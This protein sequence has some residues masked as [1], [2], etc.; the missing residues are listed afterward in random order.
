MNHYLNIMKFSQSNLERMLNVF[1][2]DE[3]KAKAESNHENNNKKQERSPDV[4]SE[5]DLTQKI[6][7]YSP[8]NLNRDLLIQLGYGRVIE[9]YAV[10][11]LIGGS[12]RAKNAGQLGDGVYGHTYVGMSR[13]GYLETLDYLAREIVLFHEAAHNKNPNHAEKQIRTLQLDVMGY[14]GIN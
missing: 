2:N 1:L 6:P 14:S 5:T 8:A 9:W 12:V 7:A 3:F 11:N 4:L 10:I 13:I